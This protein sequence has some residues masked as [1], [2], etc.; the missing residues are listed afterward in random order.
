MTGWSDL[1]AGGR[2][3]SGRGTIRFFAT[4]AHPGPEMRITALAG[5]QYG[6]RRADEGTV[7]PRD[8]FAMGRPG[9]EPG[10]DGL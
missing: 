1:V 4:Q 7:A 10:T 3:S 2:R 5:H 8:E 9:L 6:S